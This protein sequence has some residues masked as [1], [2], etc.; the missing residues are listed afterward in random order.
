MFERVHTTQ[1][2]NR[3][4]FCY[5]NTHNPPF[6]NYF[7]R[8]QPTTNK[9][10]KTLPSFSLVVENQVGIICTKNQDNTKKTVYFAWMSYVYIRTDF[11]LITAIIPQFHN[12]ACLTSNNTPVTSDLLPSEVY[13]FYKKAYSLHSHSGFQETRKWSMNHFK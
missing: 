1:K 13:F 4:S 12:P 10:S 5:V 7:V 11:F 3:G 2:I 8:I 9:I 6:K